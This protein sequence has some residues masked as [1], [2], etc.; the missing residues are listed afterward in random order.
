ML[1]PIP[2]LAPGVSGPRRPNGHQEVV[3]A[4]RR[5]GFPPKVHSDR[6]DHGTASC[7]SLRHA[8]RSLAAPDL[9]L[10]LAEQTIEELVAV[11]LDGSTGDEIVLGSS[12]YDLG[13][14]LEW[15]QPEAKPFRE[16]LVHPRLKGILEE[17]LGT[18]YRM[19]HAPDL[20]RMEN[21]GDGQ[22]LHG[23]GFERYDKGGMLEGYQ[24]HAGKMFAGMVVVEWMLAD[25][26][27]GDGGVAVVQG[28]HKSNYPAPMELKTLDKYQQHVTEVHAR[29]GDVVIFC[30]AC[31]SCVLLSASHAS[32]PVYATQIQQESS[33]VD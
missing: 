11:A 5:A 33:S 28:S 23:G 13:G 17:I 9:P 22:T 7:S 12:R 27:P 19:D 4:L 16:L 21:G 29:K 8:L 2:P 20:M 25:E 26:G 3:V 18:G 31:A 24:F 30:E 10:P 1:P 15:A 6:R 32:A 14:M